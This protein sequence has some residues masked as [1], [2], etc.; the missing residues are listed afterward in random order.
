REAAQR[1]PLPAAGLGRDRRT[2]Q[3]DLVDRFRGQV[4]EGL[5]AGPGA[6]EDDRGLRRED[7]VVA[8]EIE[9]H[10]VGA[11]IDQA[12]PLVCL[13]AGEVACHGGGPFVIS[14]QSVHGLVSSGPGSGPGI[15]ASW[16][17]TPLWAVRLPAKGAR[18]H[19]PPSCRKE[20]HGRAGSH[21]VDFWFDPIC[22]RAWIASRWLLEVT[23]LWP[24][25]PGGM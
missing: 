17:G 9:V 15:V 24:V 12:R 25:R 20:R 21:P 23:E 16:V 4:D 6:A 14:S 22:P 11:D 7:L 10:A 19:I 18:S 1:D 2:V 5:G 13:V 3:R 8:G